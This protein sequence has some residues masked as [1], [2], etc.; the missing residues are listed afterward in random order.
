MSDTV[1]A[2][3]LPATALPPPGGVRWGQPPR[4]VELPVEVFAQSD[5]MNALLGGH[6][7]AIGAR[8]Y[9]LWHREDMAAGD[10]PLNAMGTA[11]NLHLAGG[12]AVF[13]EGDVVVTGRDGLDIAPLSPAAVSLLQRLHLW[14][15]EDVP[16]RA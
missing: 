5:A 13:L 1:R 14:P 16:E 8:E 2:V 12:T 10:L 4:F 7:S 9:L 6:F 15:Q 3:L 11:A